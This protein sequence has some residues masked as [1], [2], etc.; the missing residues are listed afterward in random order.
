MKV[1]K[2]NKRNFRIIPE[3]KTVICETQPY[4]I[5]KEWENQNSKVKEV[6]R[7]A[8]FQN[9]ISAE[10][11]YLA[12]A[13]C[14]ERDEFDEKKGID[15]ASEKADYLRHVYAM[16]YY[17]KMFSL[18]TDAANACDELFKIH[19]KKAQTIYDDMVRTYGWSEE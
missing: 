11:Y 19:T 14:D 12:R 13:Y 2:K 16:K 8:A 3:N 15:I 10:E 5:W 17:E 18:L 1:V 7:E 4:N 6:L 9:N